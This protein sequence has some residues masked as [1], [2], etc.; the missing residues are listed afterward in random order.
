MLEIHTPA[1]SAPE[2]QLAPTLDE[3]AREGA[4]CMLIAA[5]EAEVAHYIYIWVD[6]IYFNVRLEEDRAS[7]CWS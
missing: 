1:N 7:A 6:G 3:I 4:R 5:L 2:D